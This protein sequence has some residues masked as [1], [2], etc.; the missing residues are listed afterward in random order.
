MAY[1]AAEKNRLAKLVKAAYPEGSEYRKVAAV[2]I[3]TGHPD[4]EDYIKGNMSEE[5]AIHLERTFCGGAV[6]RRVQ[7]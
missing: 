5:W 1:T 6:D 3:G 2:L 4:A 7:K